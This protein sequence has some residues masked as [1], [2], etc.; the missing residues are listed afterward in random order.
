VQLR[1]L[2]TF[3]HAHKVLWVFEVGAGGCLFFMVVSSTIMNPA[4]IFSYNVFFFFFFFPS[5]FFKDWFVFF[6]SPRY[7]AFCVVNTAPS[8]LGP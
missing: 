2:W 1:F 7:K 5:R 4:T 3:F 6:S 8:L